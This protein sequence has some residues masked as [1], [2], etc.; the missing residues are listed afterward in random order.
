VTGVTPE[1]LARRHPEH[2]EVNAWF[3]DLAKQR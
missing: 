3:D 2:E 1:Q